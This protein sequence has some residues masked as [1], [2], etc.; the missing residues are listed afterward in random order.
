MKTPIGLAPTTVPKVGV[1]RSGCLS[2][3]AIVDVIIGGLRTVSGPN[4][5]LSRAAFITMSPSQ[6]ECLVHDLAAQLGMTVS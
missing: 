1:T 2:G 4:G 3:S 5:T 6:A